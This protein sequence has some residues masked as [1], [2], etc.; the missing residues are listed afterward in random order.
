M[1]RIGEYQTLE[2]NRTVD[3]G[4]YLGDDELQVL[5]PKKQVPQ[6]IKVGDE[7]DVFVYRDSSD[8]LIATT[9]KPF[10]TLGEVAM[11]TVK[12]TTKIGAFMEWGLEKDLLLPFKEQTAKV[13]V[14]E[15]Y[16]VA[17]YIDKSNR[18]C[19][20]MKVYDYLSDAAPYKSEDIVKGTVYNYNPEYG[21]FVA[22][23][24]KYHGMI[25]KKEA[26][27]SFRIGEKIEARVLSVR[28]DGKMD[29]SVR[30]KSYLQ[31]EENADRIYHK[32]QELGGKLSYTDKASPEVIKADFQMSK[33]D[34]KKAIGRLL[35]ENK[36]IIGEN[37]IKMSK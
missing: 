14:G 15:E 8:R 32:I 13:Q 1:I 20:T 33:N 22:V 17:L 19:A 21:V 12:Q 26:T 30:Q 5:L 23:D 10:I 35:K 4:V 29:L 37:Y 16:L 36:I 9:N 18:L 27:R 2:V 6:G 11:L 24:N 7:I 25:Q 31:I 34:F 3:F 28:A